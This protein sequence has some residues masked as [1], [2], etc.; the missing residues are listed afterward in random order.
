MSVVNFEYKANDGKTIFAKKWSPE[1]SPVGVLQ[2]AHGM[3][4]H[5]ERYNE[6]AEFMTSKGFIVYANDHR[7]HGKTAEPKKLGFFAEKDGWKLVIDDVYKL[8]ELIKDENKDLPIFLLGHSMG[9]FISRAYLSKYDTSILSGVILSGTAATAGG[10]V[11]F[12]KFVSSMQG[13]FKGKAS[14][15]KLMTGLSFKGY[16]DKFKPTKTPFDWLSRDD[17][18]NKN[19]WEDKYCGFICTNGFFYDMLSIIEFINTKDALNK[20]PKDLPLFFISGSM[21]PVG[22]FGKGVKKV[23]NNYKTLGVKDIKM[24]LYEGGRH[25]SLNETNRKEVY[26]DILSWIQEHNS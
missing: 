17:E 13:V 3:A 21:D 6:F 12:G 23:Y 22:E 15:S 11:S 10:L 2:I 16:N 14:R 24:K 20:F 1:N 26:D 18:R 25:E 9:S 8:T 4:E 5:V 7:G 19:Y